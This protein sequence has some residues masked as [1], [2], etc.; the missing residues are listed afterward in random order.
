MSTPVLLYLVR[1]MVCRWRE[2]PFS[3]LAK[4]VVA[5]L[6]SGMAA[7]I[8]ISFHLSAAE[9]RRNLE[10]AGAS[11]VLVHEFV[12]MERLA[13]RKWVEEAV[14]P[15]RLSVVHY[16][17]KLPAVAESDVRGGIPVFLVDAEASWFWM[18]TETDTAML[19]LTEELPAGIRMPVN[20]DGSPAVA[21][22]CPRPEW[23]KRMVSGPLIVAPRERFLRQGLFG[24]E[25]Y[26]YF[27]VP[28]GADRVRSVVA[29]INLLATESGY[30][31]V[32]VRDPLNLISRL[33][34]LEA[35]Q[36]AWRTA[37]V[38]GFGGT[39]ALV[40]G[41]IA[42]LEFRERRFVCALLRS[43]GLHEGVI[44]LRYAIDALLVGNVMLFLTT[45]GV[46]AAA[47]RILPSLG[48]SEAAM[49]AM[50][51]TGFFHQDGLALMTFVNLGALLSVVPTALGL[52]KSIG[53]VLA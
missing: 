28:G 2:N 10:S 4:A 13:A 26:T 23:I 40:L 3:L 5:G 41:V 37:I 35:N 33:D 45:F 53:R 15:L 50:D 52:R 11:S 36:E 24:L 42:F 18:K 25:S 49:A 7:V 48:V 20:V 39:L 21:V 30:K 14:Q 6:L 16:M 12:P 46:L 47:G 29:A 32:T 38:A 17:E 19:F 44:L 51:G 8:L 22:T 34:V 1:D 31:G 27:E 9:I 43:F